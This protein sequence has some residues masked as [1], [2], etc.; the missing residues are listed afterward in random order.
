[1]E[2]IFPIC[3][4]RSSVTIFTELPR[5]SERSGDSPQTY[6]EHMSTFPAVK[7]VVVMENVI[8]LLGIELQPLTGAAISTDSPRLYAVSIHTF[9]E[10]RIF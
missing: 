3:P 5:L 7:I 1:M 4:A 10:F 9:S 8:S 6:N 2:H